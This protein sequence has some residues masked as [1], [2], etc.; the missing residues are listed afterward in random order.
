M[1]RRL[2]RIYTRTGD[3]G[4]TGLSD[5]SR[6]PKDDPRLETIG[7][8]DELNSALGVLLAEDM[9]PPLRATLAPIQH[10]LLD[11]GGELSLPGHTLI[12]EGHVTRLERELDLLNSTLPALTEFV[13]PGGTRAAAAAH[14]ARTI[15]RRAERRLVTLSHRDTVAPILHNYL[16]RLSDLLFVAARWLNRG[17]GSGEA[18]WEQG[19]HRT[20][21]SEKPPD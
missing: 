1:A 8:V 18:M 13:L 12:D 4:S 17:A 16:N 5:G 19:K 15:C 20:G 11:L 6:V 9:P 10:D 2:T 3:D 7:A 14:L 21:G